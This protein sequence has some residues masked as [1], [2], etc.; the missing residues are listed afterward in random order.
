VVLEDD[1][2]CEV[3]KVAHG[4]AIVKVVDEKGILLDK[5]VFLKKEGESSR[6][7]GSFN[8]REDRFMQVRTDTRSWACMQE[9]QEIKRRRSGGGGGE[10]KFSCNRSRRM[11]GAAYRHRKCTCGL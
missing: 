11:C 6:V 5:I 4:E 1:G 2:R 3:G 7:I 8:M 9:W 10:V